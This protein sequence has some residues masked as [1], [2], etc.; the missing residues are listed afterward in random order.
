MKRTHGSD[1]NDPLLDLHLQTDE[2]DNELSKKPKTKVVET[3]AAAEDEDLFQ[4]QEITETSDNVIAQPLET[5]SN[6]VSKSHNENGN[7]NCFSFTYNISMEL[8]YVQIV[9]SS[10]NFSSV[11]NKLLHFRCEKRHK[12]NTYNR[13]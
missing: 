2:C 11:S 4:R 1:D 6:D 3:T 13:N 9:C 5:D 7:I 12:Q 8:S 10:L